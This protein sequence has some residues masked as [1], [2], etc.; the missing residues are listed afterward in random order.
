M[1]VDMSNELVKQNINFME[2]PLWTLSE[3]PQKELRVTNER[4]EYIL[5]AG[6][7]VPERI[8]MNFLLFFLMTSQKNGYVQ[9][10]ELTRYDV[11]R[12]CGMGDRERE[13]ERLEEGLR[14]WKY[15]GI[16]FKGTFYDNKSYLTKAFGIINEYSIDE[17]TKKLKIEFNKSFLE[18]VKGSNFCK[19]IDFEKY[20]RLRKPVSSRLY[21]ILLKTFRERKEW[22]IEA[23][24]L[25][26][27]LTLGEGGK[28]KLYPADVKIKIVPAVN[29][30]NEKT[31]LRIEL[32]TRKNNDK[33]VIFTFKLLKNIEIEKQEQENNEIQELI[34]LLK[35]GYKDSKG[36]NDILKRHY[37]KS[38]YDYVKYNILYAN[39]KATKAYTGFLKTALMENWGEALKIEEAK[40][41]KQEEIRRIEVEEKRKTE[42]EFKT[43]EDQAYQT[44]LNI[45]TFVNSL[46]DEKKTG[47]I[48]SVLDYLQGKEEIVI[49]KMVLN[50]NSEIRPATVSMFFEAFKNCY[51]SYIQLNRLDFELVN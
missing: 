35:D 14:R 15:L 46:G 37:I 41:I 9:K 26:E 44:S 30:I 20:K 1:A 21:E 17:K 23:L 45:A 12:E 7:K 25:A 39:K 48:N 40:N 8:D 18:M 38:G 16:E 29:E 22:E 13:Y 42:E 19:Y 2:N 50:S 36:L 47:F 27:K 3:Y 32:E 6:H 4:G 31:E 49:A 11:L 43:R 34:D 28:K 10:L 5:K 33:Q 24:K 51:N